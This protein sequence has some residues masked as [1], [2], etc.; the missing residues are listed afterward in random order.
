MN[1][2]LMLQLIGLF[3]IVQALGIAVA[4]NLIGMGL[5][6]PIVTENPEDVVNAAGLFVYILIFTGA[7]LLMI[8]FMKRKPLYWL[9]KLL[10][11]IAVFATSTIV[12]S[13]FMP[14]I[15]AFALAFLIVLSRI[16]YAQN[17]LLRNVASVLAVS[18]AGAVIGV[19]LGVLP[20]MV[21]IALLAVYDLIA[22]FKTKHMVVM[23]KSITKMNLAF[24]FA[25]PA[26]GELIAE[27]PGGRKKGKLVKVPAHMFEL[28]TGDMVIPLMF[29]SSAMNASALAFP[30]YL[31]PALLI[32]LGSIA[33]LVITVDYSSR[34]V[35]K[36]L[37]A[38]PLQVVIMLVLYSVAKFA[39][40]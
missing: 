3:L 21:F 13:V 36:A 20:V 39:G 16:I 32:L 17:V 5:S 7:L 19:S 18:G 34:H 29:A 1:R 26:R 25:M 12:F 6:V 31:V 4:I 8:L 15:I 30:L 40:F 23:A 11:L 14:E 37:P 33:G 22:V 28:G 24:T 35:G 9:M 38:L 27:A 2:Q 10:E